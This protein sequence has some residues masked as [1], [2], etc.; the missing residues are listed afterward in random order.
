MC[1]PTLTGS[2]LCSQCPQCSQSQLTTRGRL[3]RAVPA[4]IVQVTR[5]GD[6]DAAATGTGELVGGAGPGWPRGTD[7]VLVAHSTLFCQGK[8]GNNPL[9]SCEAQVQ[10]QGAGTCETPKPQAVAQHGLSCNSLRTR[11]GPHLSKWS[12]THLHCSH[13][14]CPHRRAS[15]WGC[16]GCSCT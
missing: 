10:S 6:G 7:G 11:Q 13:S 8:V 14:R 5:P 16:S 9:G 2:A 1:T 3:V 15:G 4:V 12:W